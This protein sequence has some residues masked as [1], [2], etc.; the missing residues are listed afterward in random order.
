MFFFFCNILSLPIYRKKELKIIPYKETTQLKITIN[1]IWM[2][3]SGVPL[4]PHILNS[5]LIQTYIVLLN[6][7]Y[8]TL[9]TQSLQMV[10]NSLSRFLYYYQ[11]KCLSFHLLIS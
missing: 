9:T 4:E 6:K 10:Y 11:V 2:S 7:L 5:P 1:L 8:F 3:V